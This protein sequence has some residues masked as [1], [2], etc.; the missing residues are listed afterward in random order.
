LTC[1]P[2]HLGVTAAKRSQA[3]IKDIRGENILITHFHAWSAGGIRKR[4]KIDP[5]NAVSLLGWYSTIY[6]NNVDL[7]DRA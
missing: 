1:T 4:R 7:G 5:S 3:T 6:S 2:T